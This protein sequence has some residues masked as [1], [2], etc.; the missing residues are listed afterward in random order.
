MNRP[1]QRSHQLSSGADGEKVQSKLETSPPSFFKHPGRLE[2]FSDGVFAIA[3]TLLALEL[4][5]PPV[6]TASTPLR[7]WQALLE[8]WPS[9]FALLLSFGTIYAAWIGH[10]MMLQQVQDIR[11]ALV[12]TNG[13]FLLSIV[14]LPFTTALVAEHLTH[15][16]APVAVAIYA[17]VNA[18]TS[19]MYLRL[20]QVSQR[21]FTEA[22]PNLRLASLGAGVGLALCGG[23]VILAFVTP[24]GAL[25]LV[26][27]VWLWWSLPDAGRRA[28]R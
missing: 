23:A 8:G 21:H 14:L 13:L 22:S 10:H 16:G 5:V 15:P 11:P 24:I 3:I 2:A 27:C 4:R 6:E 25:L 12:W 19:L 20:Y 1:Q 26:A 18:L 7:L 9:Y 28:Q 17:G